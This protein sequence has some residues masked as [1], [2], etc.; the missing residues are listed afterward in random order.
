[1]E[2]IILR[3]NNFEQ[4]RKLINQNKDKKI[5]FSGDDE[6]NRKVLEKE[7]IQVLLLPQSEKKDFHK[8]RNSGLNQVLTRLAKKKE[9]SMGID[10]DEII[11]S[12]GK[13]RAK[14]LARVMQNIGLC[15]KAKL[16]MEFICTEHKINKNDLIS[17]GLTLG[18]PTWMISFD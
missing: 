4:A 18:M 8:Q 2:L 9:I 7:K 13:E 15:K 1:M 3:A 16:K 12:E 11:K 14:I 6:T 5:I 10:F 17:F